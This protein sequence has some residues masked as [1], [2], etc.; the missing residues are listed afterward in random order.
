LIPRIMISG[1][2]NMYSFILKM[3]KGQSRWIFVILPVLQNTVGLK[4]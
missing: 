1:R 2:Q 3:R 4:K